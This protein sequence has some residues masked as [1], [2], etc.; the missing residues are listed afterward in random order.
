LF[1][2]LPYLNPAY[3]SQSRFDTRVWCRTASGNPGFAG[4]RQA[5]LAAKRAGTIGTFTAETS[6]GTWNNSPFSFFHPRRYA[7][8]PNPNPLNL[9]QSRFETRVWCRTASGNPGFAGVRRASPAA[10]RAAQCKTLTA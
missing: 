7:T 5:K 10:K 2:T 6:T 4:I 3:L 1:L 9:S 8:V